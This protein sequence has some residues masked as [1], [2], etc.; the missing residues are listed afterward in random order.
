M[1]DGY[2]WNLVILFSEF[3]GVRGDAGSQMDVQYH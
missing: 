2:G 3:W 1:S